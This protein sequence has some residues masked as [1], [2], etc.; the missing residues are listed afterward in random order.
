LIIFGTRNYGKTSKRRKPIPAFGKKNCPE[1][2]GGWGKPKR[3]Q[4]QNLWQEK[5]VD[6]SRLAGGHFGEGGFTRAL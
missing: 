6:M 2:I 1:E 4:T 3:K 5:K